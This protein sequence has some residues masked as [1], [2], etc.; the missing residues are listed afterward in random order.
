MFGAF[1]VGLMARSAGAAS[2]AFV[3]FHFIIIRASI[4]GVFLLSMSD[5]AFDVQYATTFVLYGLLGW[6]LAW[7]LNVRPAFAVYPFEFFLQ[8][9]KPGE[10]TTSCRKKMLGALLYRLVMGAL[11]CLMMTATSLPFEMFMMYKP[12]LIWVG[13][14]LTFIAFVI[15]LPI[16]YFMWAFKRPC[17]FSKL[18]WK[19]AACPY[20]CGRNGLSY[21]TADDGDMT[22]DVTLYMMI[23][24]VVTWLAYCLVA[25][26][27]PGFS[28]FIIMLIIFGA[29][30]LF[31]GFARFTWLFLPGL[32]LSRSRDNP[33]DC[34]GCSVRKY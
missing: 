10:E 30:F 24:Y 19:R 8:K 6:M 11:T 2:L 7:A 4:K 3:I 1:I 14:C 21:I 9:G 34:D 22:M 16:F 20:R 29:F 25:I 12:S 32:R 28:S 33:K 17:S 27:A 31:F 26:L 18:A 13:F 5:F 15:V 23:F